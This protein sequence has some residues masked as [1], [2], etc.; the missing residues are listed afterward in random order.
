MRVALEAGIDGVVGEC[1]GEMTCG[2]CHVYVRSSFASLT[3]ASQAEEDL[4]EFDPHVA[5]E[6][7]L[8]CQIELSDALE[9]IILE[10][11]RNE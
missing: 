10:V 4:L 8:A 9:G 5:S 7:R 2:T 11:P 6:S 1:G 3:P